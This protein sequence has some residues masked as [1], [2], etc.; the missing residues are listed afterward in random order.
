MVTSVYVWR[1]K[2]HI[3]DYRFFDGNYLFE[4]TLLYR[5]VLPK[6]TQGGF[7]WRLKAQENHL[8]SARYRS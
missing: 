7:E 4:E 5:P 1:R 3:E 6:R 2:H 8:N